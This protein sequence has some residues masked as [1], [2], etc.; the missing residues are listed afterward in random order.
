[1]SLRDLSFAKRYVLR[2]LT[3]DDP[4][5]ERRCGYARCAEPI[6][7]SGQGRPPEYCPDR[8]WEGNRTCKQLAAVERA[9]ERAA[10]LDLPLESFRHAGERFV[11]A[12]QALARQLAEVVAAVGEVRD[13]ALARVG[14][15]DRAAGAAV[16]R[17][18]D[19]EAAA[20]RARSQRVAA[21]A[22]RERAVQARHAAEAAANEVRAEAERSIVAAWQ[23][24]AAADHARGAAE[25]VAAQAT[26]RLERAEQD[27]V[28][29]AERW[30]A[31]LGSVRA[32]RDD[33]AAARGAAEARA[34]TAEARAKTA[35]AN[36]AAAEARAN[37][38]ELRARTAETRAEA[39]QER[40]AAAESALASESTAAAAAAEAHERTATDLAVVREALAD[41]RRELDQAVAARAATVAVAAQ[42]AARADRADA[43]LDRM[44][45]RRPADPTRGR[46]TPA[47]PAHARDRSRGR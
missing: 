35:E 1:M 30:E 24:V 19:A 22:D 44:L 43:R 9:G 47:T 28:T 34:K 40:A 17:A 27:L 33:Q 32:D 3:L 23:R 5:T 41:L 29:Q 45:R 26:H 46:S 15:S 16:D 2:V 11:P 25:T 12:A 42:L 39:A 37:A 20:A 4:T 14:E 10:A 21:E 18:R 36:L 8:R 38:A 6:P 31:E 13:G 7:Y